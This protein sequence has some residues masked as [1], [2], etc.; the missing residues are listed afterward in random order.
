MESIPQTT[1]RNDEPRHDGYR[2][3]PGPEK[4]QP[5][6]PDYAVFLQTLDQLFENDPIPRITSPKSKTRRGTPIRGI[7]S[8]RNCTSP[9]GLVLLAETGSELTVAP[10]RKCEACRRW[11]RQLDAARLA[12][13]VDPVVSI[14]ADD[15]WEAIRSKL[16]RRELPYLASPLPNGRRALITDSSWD[17]PA[18]TVEDLPALLANLE[19]KRDREDGRRLSTGRLKSRQKVEAEVYHQPDEAPAERQVVGFWNSRM[20]TDSHRFT[21]ASQWLSAMCDTV[22]ASY[23]PSPLGVVVTAH[24]HAPEAEQ[25]WRALKVQWLDQALPW[26]QGGPAPE[27]PDAPGFESYWAAV[28]GHQVNEW[29]PSLAEYDQWAEMEGVA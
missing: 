17:G 27:L 18:E 2:H 14:V 26:Y 9:K 20:F 3:I 22:G 12:E 23:E 11:D 21:E 7:G 29:E 19:R 8:Q 5:G 28:A 24:R 15:E 25:L 16:K 1:N 4:L 10:C 13:A 6:S